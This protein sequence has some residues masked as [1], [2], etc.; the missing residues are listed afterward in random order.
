MHSTLPRHIK[1]DILKALVLTGMAATSTG[2]AA[3]PT[4]M[5]AASTGGNTQVVAVGGW[6][7]LNKA[8]RY[9]NTRFTC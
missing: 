9:C 4:G 5:I 6:G 7:C 2:M 8:Y 3:T 1:A